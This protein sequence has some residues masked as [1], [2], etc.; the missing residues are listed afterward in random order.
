[1]TI[2]SIWNNTTPGSSVF[3]LGDSSGVN[4]TG[5]S[6][7]AYCFAPVAGYSAFGSYTGN[8]SVDG[9]LVYTGF[10]P[11]WVMIKAS[12]GGA[13]QWFIYDTARNTSNVGNFALY[14]SDATAE[15]SI[16]LIDLLSNGF[17]LRYADTGGYTNYAGW[18]Y[19]YAAFAES[20]FAYSRAR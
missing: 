11:R 10:R 2:N 1:M 20:P 18:T 14:A 5:I 6:H 17:K 19:I 3:T 15:T 13:T 12:A 9:P 7:V 8:G 4:E 16:L